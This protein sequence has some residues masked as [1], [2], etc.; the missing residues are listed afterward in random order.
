MAPANRE[1]A[2]RL[3]ACCLVQ[4]CSCGQRAHALKEFV[5][6][7][8]LTASPQVCTVLLPALVR[9]PG[10]CHKLQTLPS[11]RALVAAFAQRQA[12]ITLGLGLKLQRA[13]AQVRARRT[14][15]QG[16]VPTHGSPFLAMIER[17]VRRP[18][19]NGECARATSAGPCLGA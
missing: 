12:V 1:C 18:S 11:W 9:H 16:C 13:L 6:T 5:Q 2:Q 4:A 15:A 7:Q 14:C 8:V 10:I 17:S 3:P 19:A